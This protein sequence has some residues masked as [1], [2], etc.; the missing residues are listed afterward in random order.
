MKK[1]FRHVI[2]ACFLLGIGFT[3]CSKDSENPEGSKDVAYVNLSMIMPLSDAES[4]K[5]EK[6]FSTKTRTATAAESKVNSIDVL[7]YTQYGT[8]Q[9][10]NRFEST[11]FTDKG[12]GTYEINNE[13]ESTVGEKIILVGV[14]LPAEIAESV[15]GLAYKDF[16]AKSQTF[17]KATI[18]TLANGLPMFSKVAKKQTLVKEATNSVEVNVER[19]V[20]KITVEK[21]S[22]MTMGIADG[23]LGQLQFAIQNFNTKQYLLPHDLNVDPNWKLDD[24]LSNDFISVN[25]ITDYV[26]V[27]EAGTSLADLKTIYASENT[28]EGKRKKE[29]TYATVRATFVPKE[30]LVYANGTDNQ[31]GYKKI[32]NTESSA[33]TFYMLVQASLGQ[34]YTYDK[35][36]AEAVAVENGLTAASVITYTGGYCYWYLWLNKNSSQGEARWDIIRNNFQRCTIQGITTIGRPKEI[37]ND[38]VELEKTP[39]DEASIIVL[40]NVLDWNTAIEDDYILGN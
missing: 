5:S 38:P 1:N 2:I 16:N 12:D 29:I 9:S 20:A 28:S 7:I 36:F 8:F 23:T 26:N 24:Y 39:E 34:F 33:K 27:S 17:S 10:H 21:A 18:A 31:N 25:A 40:I 19:M 30:V 3:S 35:T 37:V 4:A 15:E 13:I 11:D 6:S 32:T 22:D 14:N